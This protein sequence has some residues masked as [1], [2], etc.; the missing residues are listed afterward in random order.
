MSAYGHDNPYRMFRTVAIWL[1][2]LFYSSPI[3]AAEGPFPGT[4]VYNPASKSYFQLFTDN[5]NPGNWEAAKSRAGMKS[6]KGVR[7]RLAVIESAKTHNFVVETF[8]LTRRQA[9]V[10]IGL[11]YW[12]NAHLLQWE[13][14]RAYS[15]SDPAHFKIWHTQWSRTDERS[16]CSF[17]QSSKLGFAPVYYRTIGGVTRWQAVGAAKYFAYYL[18]EFPTG[19]E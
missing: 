6:F 5:E 10:W 9:S 7:G 13:V 12:C 15:P 11:R 14:G 17:T 3:W 4:P 1:F 18:V 8:D 16:A 19:K 2:C